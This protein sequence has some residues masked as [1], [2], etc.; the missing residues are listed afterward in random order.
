VFPLALAGAR[1]FD[2]PSR[3]ATAPAPRLKC[4]GGVEFRHFLGAGVK[5]LAAAH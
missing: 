3:A 1:T 5:A 2:S 4:A